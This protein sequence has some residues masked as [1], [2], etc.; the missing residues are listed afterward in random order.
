MLWG[1]L[2]IGKRYPASQYV[3]ALVIIL[4]CTAFAVSGD[5]KSTVLS[6]AE[7]SAGAYATG[8]ALMI[9]YLAADGYTSTHQEKLF[10]TYAM[11]IPDQMLF[12]TAFSCGFS[13]LAAVATNQ[14]VPAVTFMVTHPDTIWPILGLSVVSAFIQ[15][16]IS[17][18]VKQHG[19]LAF[20]WIM[21]TRQFCSILLSSVVFMH[22]LTTQQWFGVTIVFGTLYIQ[23]M[24]KLKPK[25][26]TKQLEGM[27][28]P[29]THPTVHIMKKPSLSRPAVE[30]TSQHH[31]RSSWSQDQLVWEGKH[32]AHDAVQQLK[33]WVEPH[34]C[35]ATLS[36]KDHV[37]MG[38]SAAASKSVL[39]S[40]SLV[41]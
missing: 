14:F 22:P 28:L 3:F 37:I 36:I 38:E 25:P 6:A 20:A 23:N 39:A 26:S 13:L 34:D 35:I 33:T 2:V 29:S 32:I 8:A 4:G 24:K 7:A 18:V 40:Y 30:F 15:L 16:F 10:K 41:Y 21:T 19:A 1:T 9:V 17:H 31:E 11:P 5:S 12:T 27:L